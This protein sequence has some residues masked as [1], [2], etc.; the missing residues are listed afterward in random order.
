[1]LQFVEDTLRISL[2]LFFVFLSSMSGKLTKQEKTKRGR[3]DDIF[4]AF[5]ILAVSIINCAIMQFLCMY[6]TVSFFF[7]VKIK[8]FFPIYNC[9]VIIY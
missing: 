3:L 2:V 9:F 7:I 4:F 1:M 6:V 8:Y 5:L